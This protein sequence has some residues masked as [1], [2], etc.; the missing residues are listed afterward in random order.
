MTEKILGLD[1]C[2]GGWM[3]AVVQAGQLTAL[4]FHGSIKDTLK[5]HQDAAICAIDIPIGL[6]SSGRRKADCDAKA[7]LKEYQPGSGRSRSVFYSP[8]SWVLDRYREDKSL[9]L[10]DVNGNLPT[11][12]RLSG[13]VWG[14]MRAIAEASDLDPPK[15]LR[16]REVHPEV[17]FAAMVQ[18]GTLL[19]SK[20]TWNG[21]RQRCALLKRHGLSVPPVVRQCHKSGEYPAHDILDSVACA[22]S[23][24]RLARRFAPSDSEGDQARSLPDGRSDGCRRGTIWY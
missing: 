15:G 24:L 1:G 2:D 6:A 11:G 14:M 13:Q 3:C 4:Q 12:Q 9:S 18:D 5:E 23:G 10:K 8:P 22:W 21:L 17:S 16:I 19:G 7:F 20:H